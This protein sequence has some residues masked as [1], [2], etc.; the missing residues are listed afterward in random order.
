MQDT[1]RIRIKSFYLIICVVINLGFLQGQAFIER[2]HELNVDLSGFDGF[3]GGGVSFVDI[4]GDGWDDLSFATGDGLLPLF[5][6]NVGG[7]YVEYQLKGVT[8][9]CESKSVLWIDIDNDGDNDLFI[10][11]YNAPDQ[12]FVNLNGIDFYDASTDY[13]LLDEA[14]ESFGASAGDVD[15]DSFLD[16]YI[17][18]RSIHNP[19]RFYNNNMGT[20]LEE[21]TT[22]S[23]LD[24][25]F[26]LDFCSAFIDYNL[27]GFQ[28]LYISSDYVHDNTLFENPGGIFPMLDAGANT[29]SDINISAMSVSPGDFDNDQDEDIYVTN[30]PIGNEL[31]RNHLDTFTR[32]ANDLGIGFF[33]TGWAANWLDYNNDTWL[34]LYVSTMESERAK[35]NALF[36][37]NGGIVFSE[38]FFESAGIQGID[39]VRTF[40][41]ATGDLDNDGNIDIMVYNA[42]PY[43]P[44]LF[45]NQNEDNNYV[46]FSLE[47]VTSNRNAAGAK[48]LVHV[49]GAT[50][51]RTVYAGEGY[52]NQNSYFQ[53]FGLGE[54]TLID[55]VEIF[56]LGG[57]V[58]RLYNVEVNQFLQID[59]GMTQTNMTPCQVTSLITHPITTD[60]TI[61]RSKSILL[62]N[63]IS[64]PSVQLVAGRTIYLLG[65]LT[66]DLGS[67]MDVSSEPCE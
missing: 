29:G 22:S 41:N 53:H 39:T 7:R 30:I 59:E 32:E 51:M 65:G 13:S 10:S 3:L 63:D 42:S 47:G 45:H 60:E 28:D 38:P 50:L 33:R 57:N 52:L 2:S 67:S 20:S 44:Y 21:M 15:N 61:Q 19:N 40:S 64:A 48:I 62:A 56:W 46:K 18:T 4:D 35:P 5:Y 14:I 55:S 43:Q 24:N 17:S 1:K 16:L 49:D 37:N 23:G 11:C 31:L 25:G 26:R 12:L 8:A 58:D 34:D 54:A 6:R 36:K 27:D 66:V 9:I